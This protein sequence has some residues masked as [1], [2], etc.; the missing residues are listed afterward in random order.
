MPGTSQVDT[1][2][3]TDPTWSCGILIATGST[4]ASFTQNYGT[5]FGSLDFEHGITG[6]NSPDPVTIAAF[7]ETF[8]GGVGSATSQ[9]ITVP[10]G[11][12]GIVAAFSTIVNAPAWS[13]G[14]TSNITASGGDINNSI[15]SPI[16]QQLLLAHTTTAG[17]WQPLLTGTP[18][19]STDAVE[20]IAIV[21]ATFAPGGGGGALPQILLP[22]RRI[23]VRR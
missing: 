16:A 18:N 10:A 2:T 21:A 15:S 9:S 1:V 17:T 20:A 8:N 14:G 13:A 11:G 22:T 5:N 19:Y 23:F 6:F 4:V 3:I 12:F 7:N